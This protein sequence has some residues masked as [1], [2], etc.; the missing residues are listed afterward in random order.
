MRFALASIPATSSLSS[1]LKFLLTSGLSV[2]KSKSSF[3]KNLLHILLSVQSDTNARYMNL[4]SSSV[5]TAPSGNSSVTFLYAFPSSSVT[6]YPKHTISASAALAKLTVL[7]SISC[8]IV[9]SAS[10]N[11]MNSPLACAIRLQRAFSMPALS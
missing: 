4:R 9:S 11:W 6:E 8:E 10:T 3:L 7:S 1:P 5:N 2:T